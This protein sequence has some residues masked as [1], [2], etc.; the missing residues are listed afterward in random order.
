MIDNSLQQSFRF[1]FSE[2]VVE[3]EN[4]LVNVF[5]MMAMR[6]FMVC[7]HLK[8][9]EV[10]D[11]KVDHSKIFVHF[12][13]WGCFGVVPTRFCQYPK[14]SKYVRANLEIWCTSLCDSSNLL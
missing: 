6:D 2:T 4:E 5:L 7:S 11:D 8:V 3:L 10:A 9:F 14:G 12:V 13:R 1:R